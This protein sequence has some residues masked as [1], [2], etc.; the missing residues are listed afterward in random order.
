MIDDHDIV[1]NWG[2]D[3]S[4]QT[5]A[6]RSVGE[7]ARW[8]YYDY[9]GTHVLPLREELPPSFHYNIVYGHTAVFVMDLRSQRRAGEN[10]QL[11][12]D[13]QERDLRA[14]LEENKDRKV[15]LFVLTVP[16][17]HLP[18]WLAKVG[19]RFSKDGEDFSDRWSSLA[20]VRDR[21]RFL[22]II[23]EHQ[24]RHPD[25]YV[26]LLSGD[27]HIGCAH[28][29]TWDEG[30]HLYQFVSS[31]ITN[32]VSRAIKFGS[33]LLIRFNRR[34]ATEDGDVQGDVRLVS[35][36][37]WRRWNPYGGLNLGVLEIETPRPGA[38]P[39]LRYYVYGHRGDEPVCVYRSPVL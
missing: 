5:E 23:H 1:D 8:A 15:L 13:D 7:G 24:Q 3:P 30:G 31:G 28:K 25:Q 9:Q 39:Q 2:S 18:R 14:F 16:V 17:V 36:T 11:Y 19:A 4:H 22:R 20:H 6:W 26:A 27:I 32:P 37:G 35:G 34:L 10:G 29:V 33:H 38:M 12:S 21:D